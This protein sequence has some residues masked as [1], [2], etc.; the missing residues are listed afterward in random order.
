MV[1]QTRWDG[2]CMGA[3]DLNNMNQ[4]YFDVLSEIGNIGSG[5]ATTALAQL[6]NRKID[7]SVPRVALLGFDHFTEL[8]GSEES[9]MLGILFG[10]EGDIDG[11]MMFLLHP[12]SA[13]VLVNALM[14]TDNHGQE[15]TEMELSAVNEVGNIISGAY[16][17]SLATLTNMTIVPTPPSCTLDMAGAILSVPAIEFGKIGDKMLMIETQMGQGEAING[18]FLLIPNLDSYDKI[19]S[20]LHVI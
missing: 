4:T 7:M 14:G 11:M 8:I 12:E 15:F 10:I 9:L 16:L 18:Y 6:L 2:E 3:I 1:L 17:N 19:L 5:N 13:H 20:A